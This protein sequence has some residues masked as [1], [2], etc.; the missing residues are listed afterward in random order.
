MITLH[1]I[2]ILQITFFD[3]KCKLSNYYMQRKKNLIRN[4]KKIPFKIKEDKLIKNIFDYLFLYF[5]ELVNLI[6]QILMITPILRIVLSKLIHRFSNLS[7]IV[8]QVI[9]FIFGIFLSYFLFF[10]FNEKDTKKIYIFCFTIITVTFFTLIFS[11]STAVR[12][13]ILLAIPKIIITQ[14][15]FIILYQISVLII[16][17]PL[18]TIQSNTQILSELALCSAKISYD[19]TM[20]K[21]KESIKPILIVF[22]SF[23]VLVDEFGIFYESMKNFLMDALKT[24]KDVERYLG[25]Y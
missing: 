16:S 17:G 12:C 20:E 3:L 23:K 7:L 11:L 25:D 9:A 22:N 1:R 24:I 19:L 2:F 5:F 13:I 15:R 18:I 21:M 14:L 4:R 10:V 8:R 6:F